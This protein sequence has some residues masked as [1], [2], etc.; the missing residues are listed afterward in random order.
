ML[1]QI[2][3]QQELFVDSQNYFEKAYSLN[4]NDSWLINS[5]SQVYQKNSHNEKA[6]EFAWLAILSSPFDNDQHINFGYILYEIYQEKNEKM[7]IEYANKWLANFSNNPIA[8]HM[9]NAILNNKNIDKANDVYV[10]KIFDVFAE[11]FEEVLSSLEYQVPQ[12][13]SNMLK[14]IYGD[15]GFKKMKILDAGCGTGLCGK[16]LKKYSSIFSLYGVD[17]SSQMLKKAKEKKCYNKLFESDLIEFLK[18]KNNSF[19]LIV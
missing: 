2:C 10:K 15:A 16:F 11:E 4:K 12:K 17:L 6:V 14:D 7:A 8:K 13:I 19:D 5:L 9:G 3:F 18:N 1:G